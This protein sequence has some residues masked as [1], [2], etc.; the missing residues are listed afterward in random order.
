MNI[1]I[2]CT[3]RCGSTS[4]IEACKHIDNFTSGH[5]T[6]I[7]MIG[8]ER[9][10]YPENHIEA[11]PRLAFFLGQLEKKYGKTAF[12]V[13]LIRDKKAT[14]NSLNKRWNIRYTIVK[15]YLEGIILTPEESVDDKFKYQVCEDYY[16]MVNDNIEVFLE[17]KPHKMTIHLEK[18]KT[19]FLDFWN[20]INAKGNWEKAIEEWT[21]AHNAS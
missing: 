12:Y 16:D 9:L 18:I 3:G 8:K 17:N 5:E 7:R 15:A 14:V 20:M 21:H 19:D 13:H 6:R 2:L 4:F 11:D 1:F 10:N